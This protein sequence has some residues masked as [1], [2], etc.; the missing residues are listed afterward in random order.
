MSRIRI[1]GD[2]RPELEASD[3]WSD[4]PFT[5]HHFIATRGFNVG[6]KYGS[7]VQCNYLKVIMGDL[8]SGIFSH[9][10][11]GLVTNRD[12]CYC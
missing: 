5:H 2:F 8:R 9:L 12:S 7:T 3:I 11:E 6:P 10:P 1:L 4:H